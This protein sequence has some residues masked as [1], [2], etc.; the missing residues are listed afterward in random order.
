VQQEEG[1]EL[2]KHQ[3]E[4]PRGEQKGKIHPTSMSGKIA[5]YSRQTRQMPPG[6]Q[7]HYQT[8]LFEND[9]QQHERGKSIE[10]KTSTIVMNEVSPSPHGIWETRRRR[11]VVLLQCHC[12][13]LKPNLLNAVVT[14]LQRPAYFGER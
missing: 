6:E 8:K 11:A 10:E 12:V 4:A 5:V 9:S 2:F 14:L 3:D 13:T 1:S 7:T